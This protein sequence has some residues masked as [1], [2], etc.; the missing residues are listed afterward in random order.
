MKIFKRALFNPFSDIKDIEKYAREVDRDLQD[1]TLAFSN[2]IRFGSVTDGNRG[3]NISG[4]FQIF[5]SD[6]TPDTEFSV[7]H[8]LGATPLGHLIMY[9]D[10]AGSLYQGP[11]TGTAWDSTDIYLKCDVA[12]VEFAVFLLK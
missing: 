8:T 10:K 5:T 12:S 9:Q 7:A 3:E 1:I 6:A 4:E 11:S 2:R